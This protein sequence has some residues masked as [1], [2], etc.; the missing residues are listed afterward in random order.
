MI[1][2]P[3]DMQRCT[4][5][6]ASVGGAVKPYVDA[7]AEAT[8]LPTRAI[9]GAVRT[10]QVA[11]ARQLVM[12]LAHRDGMSAKAIGRGLHRDHSTVLHGVRREAERRE[13]KGITLDN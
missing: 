12:Y 13:I 11:E 6:A 7:V 10:R 2:S 4:T 1:L 8:G 5:I 9:Y 3:A